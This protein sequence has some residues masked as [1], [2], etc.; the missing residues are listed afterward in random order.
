[1][2][3]NI[4]CPNCQKHNVAYQGRIAHSQIVALKC[5]ECGH[6]WMDCEGD[7]PHTVT[8]IVAALEY[9]G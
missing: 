3:M 7:A 9:N 6:V 4:E 5:Y 1:M 8:S 2:I